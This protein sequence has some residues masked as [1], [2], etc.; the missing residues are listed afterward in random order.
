MARSAWELETSP[1][2]RRWREASWEG[3][4]ARSTLGVE[5]GA[6]RPGWKVARSTL[7][8]EG[9]AKHPGREGG[10]T[11]WEWKVARSTLGVEGG[12]KHPGSGRW[13]EAPWEWKVARSTLGV[14]TS[15]LAGKVARSAGWGRSPGSAVQQPTCPSS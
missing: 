12:A 5:G 2:R 9:G 13:R 15:P 3:K 11:P 7:G 4:V 8:V 6:K 10:R 1:K 14:K